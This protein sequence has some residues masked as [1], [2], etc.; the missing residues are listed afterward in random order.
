MVILNIVHTWNAKDEDREQER[1]R[2]RKNS[3]SH[4][5]FSF[6]CICSFIFFLFSLQR[7]FICQQA[8]SLA[9]LSSYL[10][11]FPPL[12]L[13]LV[14]FVLVFPPILSWSSHTNEEDMQRWTKIVTPPY[15]HNG[16]PSLFL[17]RIRH[18]IDA[19]RKK[20]E[21]RTAQ[22][23]RHWGITCQCLGRI[24]LLNK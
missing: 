24:C 10:L 13:S 18:Q 15:R 22:E 2:E 19:R 16:S 4:H 17:V 7:L 14:Q 1:Q 3:I 21:L 12:F 9:F 11:L 6:Q 20:E 5:H 23:K 8:A